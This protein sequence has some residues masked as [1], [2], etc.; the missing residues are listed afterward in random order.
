MKVPQ[1]C[2]RR[3]CIYTLLLGDFSGNLP[4]MFECLPPYG[5]TR[6]NHRQ[7]A[8]VSETDGLFFLLIATVLSKHA[9]TP[10]HH[11]SMK[12]DDSAAS[13]DGKFAK[14]NYVWIDFGNMLLCKLLVSFP[15]CS[16]ERKG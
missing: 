6:F 14:C 2:N 15:D 13:K 12:V 16:G 8:W 11:A 3:Y 9:V 7:S 10:H 1:I 5:V 4:A